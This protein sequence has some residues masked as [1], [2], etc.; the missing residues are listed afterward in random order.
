MKNQEPLVSIGLI[1]FNRDYTVGEAI[2]SLLSQ[3]Y[4]NFEL[5]ISDDAS[6]DDTSKVC[7]KFAE[8]DKRI[9]FFR[10]KKNIGLAANS[11]FVLKK[12]SGKYFMWASDDD[13][14]HKDFI[15]ELV[16]LLEMNNRAALA[17]PN[18]YLFKNSK[19][20]HEEAKLTGTL[21]GL[22]GVLIYLSKTPLLV[23]G[24]FRSS[25]L[26]KCGG[27][28]Q[29]N[30]PGWIKGSDFITVFKVLLNGDVIFTKKTLFY[31]R[32]SGFA[33]DRQKILMKFK[34]NDDI[35]LR[36]KRYLS[37]LLMFLFDLYYLIIFTAKSSFK[38][39]SKIKIVLHCLLWYFKVNLNHIKEI[40]FGIILVGRRFVVRK[41]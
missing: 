21:S 10:Q 31:K 20:Y 13:L 16:R 2:K 34:L 27:F 5:I 40:I 24:L 18:F 7:S 25:I 35:K 36:I 39:T 17:M 38:L 37:Y 12:S 9:R 23:W 19:K 8:K 11:N 14:W 1:A 6:T 41:I 4:K 22:P 30:R 26:K 28:H 33:V 15:S 32:D 3:S 29:D